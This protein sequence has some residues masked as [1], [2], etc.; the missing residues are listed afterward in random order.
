MRIIKVF[1][2]SS[3]EMM[4][5]DI[6][7]ITGVIR[8]NENTLK[9]FLGN[10]HHIVNNHADL[11][12]LIKNQVQ[13]NIFGFEPPPP[14]IVDKGEENK[15]KGIRRA[16]DHAN[17]KNAGTWSDKAYHATLSYISNKK[18]GFSF[19]ME[20]VRVWAETNNIVPEPPSKR[21]WGGTPLRLVR[22]GLIYKSGFGTVKNENANKCYA[23][24]WAKL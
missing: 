4:D 17:I 20:D 22:E 7:S 1:N 3:G 16:V 21:A 6:D 18:K 9:V 2:S 23:S 11:I 14:K 12:P 13:L 19:M 15:Q 5:I 24:V 8:N 10:I